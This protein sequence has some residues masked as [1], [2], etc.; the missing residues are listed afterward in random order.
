MGLSGFVFTQLAFE[1]HS[2]RR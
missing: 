1:N 2:Q